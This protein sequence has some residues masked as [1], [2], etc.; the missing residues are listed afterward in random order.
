MSFSISLGLGLGTQGVAEAAALSVSI[1]GLTSGVARPGNVLGATMSDG[2]QILSYRWGSTPGGTEFGTGPAPSDFAAADGANLYIEATSS[3]GVFLSVAPVRYAAPSLIGQVPDQHL[4]QGTPMQALDLSSYVS[5]QSLSYTLVNPEALVAGLSLSGA[6]LAGTPT[7]YNVDQTDYDARLI[8]IDA[9]NSGG[10]VRLT[11][12]VA[13]EA[14][15]DSPVLTLISAADGAR[16]IRPGTDQPDTGSW[17]WAIFPSGTNDIASD[18]AGGWNIAPQHSGSEPVSDA[19]TELSLPYQGGVGN[20]FTFAIYQRVSGRDSNVLTAAYSAQTQLALSHAASSSQSFSHLSSSDGSPIEVIWADGTIDQASHGD[21][22]VHSYDHMQAGTVLLR[23]LGDDAHLIEIASGTGIWNF[24]LNVLPS[25]LQTL[26]FSGTSMAVTG[27]ISNLPNT[28]SSLR[29]EGGQITV[30]GDLADLPA[31]LRTV[32]LSGG[33]MDL[34]VSSFTPL[35]SAMRLFEVDA[36]LSQADLAALLSSLAQIPS[37]TDERRVVLDGASNAE[38]PRSVEGDYS[39]LQAAGVTVLL[40]VEGGPFESQPLEGGALNPTDVD[41]IFYNVHVFD[42]SGTLIVPQ[43]TLVDYLVVAGGGGGGGSTA[44]GGGGGGVLMG[45]TTL[46]ANT[47]VTVGAGGQGGRIAHDGPPNATSGENSVLG[48]L[49]ALGGGHGFSGTN[50]DPVQ[51]AADGGS[52]GGSGY[53]G[54]NTTSTETP[55]GSGTSGQGHDGG[56]AFA[57]AQWG[58][59]GGGGAGGPGSDNLGTREGGPGLASDITGTTIYYGGGGGGGVTNSGRSQGGI[60]GGGSGGDGRTFVATAGEPNSGGGGG[61][62]GY[63]QLG[64][65]GGDGGSG[66]VVVRYPQ[67]NARPSVEIINLSFDDG[68]DRWS[69]A[70]DTPSIGTWHWAR[71]A[72]GTGSAI[73]DGSGGW[74][75]SP[76]ESGILPVGENG[77][78][79]TLPETGT[80]GQAYE[81]FLYQR[82]YEQDSNVITVPYRADNTAPEIVSAT[83]TT[84]TTLSVAFSE[85]ISRASEAT[86][87]DVKIAGVTQ[88]LARA[89]HIAG[90]GTITLVLENGIFASGDVITVSYNAGTIIDANANPMPSRADIS[91]FNP[92]GLA[93]IQFVAGAVSGN[94]GSSLTETLTVDM[95]AHNGVDRVVVILGALNNG[96]N[97][98]EPLSVVLDGVAASEIVSL[99]NTSATGSIVGYAIFPVGS[100]AAQSQ[101]VISFSAVVWDAGAAVYNVTSTASVSTLITQAETTRAGS[102]LSAN[103]PEGAAVIG[104][105]AVANGSPATWSGLTEDYEADMRSN[106]WFSVAS[107]QDMAAAS[108]HLIQTTSNSAKTA[109]LAILVEAN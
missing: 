49:I 43:A 91:V 86:A 38:A 81:L 33:R 11:F 64:P 65:G 35:Q 1:T 93:E 109:A 77:D 94:T 45:T 90:T 100:Y 56:A 23:P 47:P 95:S 13:V 96:T 9:H 46:D 68:F 20:D 41:G 66:I 29:L 58:G 57:T 40:S 108:P 51:L 73:S 106:E 59:A 87:W 28:L 104:V 8:H 105:Q 52:G 63:Y 42:G 82:A 103:L 15:T 50:I 83:V 74:S 62:G 55:A 71:F 80:T 98:T 22:L 75:G 16:T 107:A 27:D 19:E 6:V 14:G 69:V 17:H 89:D 37:W 31:S 70:T 79:L 12:E 18:G 97:A 2:G 30:T 26:S 53:Y 36:N 61:G 7:G 32:R 54:G 76:I 24:D 78:G 39:S 44:G 88:S 4:F 25:G 67:M 101:L 34:N 84:A 21:G 72:S 10:A 99:P 5:G 92:L 60:G 3:E 102:D 48:D 85:P